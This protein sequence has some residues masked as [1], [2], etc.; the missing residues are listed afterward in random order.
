[1]VKLFEI[2]NVFPNPGLEVC[3]VKVKLVW[4]PFECL[5]KGGKWERN[6]QREQSLIVDTAQ[7]RAVA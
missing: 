4:C 3:E 7:R 6:F 5:C 2:R 1:M